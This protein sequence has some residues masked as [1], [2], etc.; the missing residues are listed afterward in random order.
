MTYA[1][2]DELLDRL[3]RI[4]I[5]LA[6]A[7]QVRAAI[8][9]DGGQARARFAQ[10]NVEPGMVPWPDEIV[11]TLAAIDREV[12][13]RVGERPSRFARLVAV[14]GLDAVE[15]DLVL[16]AIAPG[17][18]RGFREAMQLVGTEVAPGVHPAAHLIELVARGAARTAQARAA[19][20]DRG[21]LIASGVLVADAAHG[22]AAPLWRALTPSLVTRAWLSGEP[23]PLHALDREPAIRRAIDPATEAA[24]ARVTHAGAPRVILI[25]APG[26][27]RTRA[28]AAL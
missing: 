20:G 2:G 23:S 7:L 16:A 13:A 5:M 21:R 10:D 22:H 11:A 3:E 26:S 15:A 25:G 6:A 18:R 17:V 28:A 4:R 8:A 14:A 1:D 19:I 27:G 9:G 12:A 24:I